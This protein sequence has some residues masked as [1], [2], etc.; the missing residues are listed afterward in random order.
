MLEKIFYE[1]NHYRHSINKVSKLSQNQNSIKKLNDSSSSETVL[2]EFIICPDYYHSYKENVILKY[3][4][5]LRDMQKLKYPQNIS[6]IELFEEATYNA[7][8]VLKTISI[9]VLSTLPNTTNQRIF[10]INFDKLAIENSVN[11]WVKT[12]N[13]TS[14]G[15]CYSFQV[16]KWLRKLQVSLPNLLHFYFFQTFL[17]NF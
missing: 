11:D 10:W 6:D 14:L 3:G 15:R 13:W 4:L 5:N 12:K 7:S 8:E 16:P 17:F 1:S 2:P 9:K